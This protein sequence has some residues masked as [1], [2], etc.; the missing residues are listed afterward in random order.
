MAE[1]KP[2]EVNS[3]P[4]GAGPAG[5][6]PSWTKL[7]APSAG[8]MGFVGRKYWLHLIL[9]AVCIVV[10]VLAMVQGTLFTRTL[11]D[12]YIIPLV[13]RPGGAPDFTGLRDAIL[14]VA[15]FYALGVLASFVQTR[16]MIYVTQGSLKELRMKIFNHME[17]CP[18]AIS[19]PTPT[20]TSCRSTPTTSTPCGR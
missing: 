14:R 15:M 19:T 12:D 17:S 4:R 7:Q 11:I 2:R 3:G 10:S 5:P 9:V 16:L 13:D 6:G 20:A 8:L 18:S 1:Q